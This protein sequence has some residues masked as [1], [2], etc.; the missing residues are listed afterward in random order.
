MNR[1][2]LIVSFLLTIPA[3]SAL[4]GDGLVVEGWARATASKAR[5]G[6]AYLMIKNDTGAADKLLSSKSSAAKHA[7]LHNHTMAGS[8][9]KMR[10]VDAANVPAKGI[11][12]MKP[13]GLHI[14]LMGLKA[15]LKKGA[16]LPLALTFEKAGTVTIDVKIM[17]M[18]A[19]GMGAIH[20]KKKHTH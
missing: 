4:A 2:V 6:A 1:F 9:M 13:G 7:S 10:P 18:G 12:M 14:M 11:V 19:K 15:P 20:G 16:T 5:N 17:G 3:F 8:V